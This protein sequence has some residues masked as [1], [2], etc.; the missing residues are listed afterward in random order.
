MSSVALSVQGVLAPYLGDTLA[1]MMVRTTAISLGKA[2]E[3]LTVDDLPHLL[4]RTRSTMS[5]VATQACINA[6]TARI[7]EMMA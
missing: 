1:E 2:F 5:G 7:E 4:V 3:D 6:A